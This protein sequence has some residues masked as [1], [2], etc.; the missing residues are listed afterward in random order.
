MGKPHVK[1][2]MQ[3]LAQLPVP[4]THDAVSSLNDSCSWRSVAFLRDMLM[5]QG[6]LPPADRNLLLFQRWFT[7]KLRGLND[8]AH[9]KLVEQFT[10]WHVLRRLR[11]LADQAPV[12][13]KQVDRAHGQVN[14]AV[15]FLAWLRARDTDLERCAQADIDAWFSESFNTRRHASAF[16]KWAIKGR[17][18]GKV[19][20]PHRRIPNPM[21]L[22]QHERVELLRRL[23]QDPDIHP[24]ARVSCL[25]MALYAQPLQRILQLSV[26]DVVDADGEISIAFGDLPTPVP[27]P[28]AA[29]LRNYIANGRHPT[30]G[31]RESRWLLPSVNPGQPITGAG[32]RKHLRRHGLP[33]L[34]GRSSALHQL[35]LDAPPPVVAGMLGFTEHHLAQVAG[36]AG[37]TWSRYAAGDHQRL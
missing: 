7:E 30:P 2:M 37:L 33:A 19:E 10:A 36:Q 20:I 11:T 5:E 26:D 16:L 9:R 3:Q 15:A 31:N 21:P 25:L 12:T 32:I 13:A 14:V 6:C 22:T 4:I 24:I 17:L 1:T 29:I 8:P 34:S 27:E 23:V 28:F 35:L 18:L